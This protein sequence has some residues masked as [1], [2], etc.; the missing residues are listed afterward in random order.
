MINSLGSSIIAGSV[1]ATGSVNIASAPPA[2]NLT[3]SV[4]IS[5]GI[6]G[7]V[8]ISTGSLNVYGTNISNPS[9]Y[10]SSGIIANTGSLTYVGGVSNGSVFGLRLDTTG[11]YL[12]TTGSITS[13]PAWTGVGSFVSSGITSITGSVS[14]INSTGSVGVFGSVYQTGSVNIASAP[15]AWNLT[16]SVVVS[17]GI[18]GSVAISTGSLNVYGA[19]ISNPSIYQSS[20]IIANTGSLTYVGGV[21]NGSVF[22]LRMDTTG[23]YLLTTGSIT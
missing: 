18:L 4:V 12:L 9:I 1:Y 8:A 3:G 15:P 21:S 6:L 5:G 13:L 11:S 2:W 14:L 23:S 7:S 16:G 17:G 10:Q 19:N 20:G 22:G